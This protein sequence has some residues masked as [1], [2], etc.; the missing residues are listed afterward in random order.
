MD[1]FNSALPLPFRVLSGPRA[2]KG[3]CRAVFSAAK[4]EREE[5]PTDGELVEAC[6]S[7]DSNSFARLVE[8]YQSSAAG[9]LWHFTRD[10]LVLE[11][12]VQDAFVEAYLS[13]KRFRPEAPFFPWLRTIATRVGYRHWRRLRQQSNRR[14]VLEEW[15]RRSSADLNPRPGD[16]ADFL[17]RLLELLE[18]KD[19]L[20]LTLQYFEQC[21]TQEIAKRV[22]W[23]TSAV[24][25]R[26]FRARNRLRKLLLEAGVHE[27]GQA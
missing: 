13:L 15:Q 12:L 4:A 5:E 16:T 26:A 1:A 19:R 20:V 2:P 8:R 25:V 27:R 7:G 3:R 24:K 11:E 14:E 18:P 6:L 9:I 17:F 23:T 21:S 22:G 10:P